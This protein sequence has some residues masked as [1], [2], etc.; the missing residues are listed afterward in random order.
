MIK[1]P[2][3]KVRGNPQV[4]SVWELQNP[5]HKDMKLEDNANK[6]F[7]TTE[8]QQLQ[9]VRTC[10]YHKSTWEYHTCAVDILQKGEK[11]TLSLQEEVL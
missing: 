6:C 7:Q 4:L 2:W 11:W 10:N 1:P 5:T 8:K 9:W 3:K